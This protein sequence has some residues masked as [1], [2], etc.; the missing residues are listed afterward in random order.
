MP[1]SQSA[2]PKV[3]ILS[4][5]S[6]T[7]KLKPRRGRVARA[8]NSCR[9]KKKRCDGLAPCSVCKV[10]GSVCAYSEKRDSN[11]SHQRAGS[12]RLLSLGGSGGLKGREALI[13]LP[14]REVAL[15][16]IHKTWDNACVLFRFHYRPSIIRILNSLYE[17]KDPSQYTEEQIK[18]QP[19]IYS[20]L[21]VGVLFAKEDL[22]HTDV[23]ARDF[24]QDE[25][26]KYFLAAKSLV[27]VTNINDIFAIQ[28]MFMMTMF[29]Q[30]SANLKK[31]YAYIGIALRAA[32]SEG[33]HRKNSLVGPTP[34]EDETKKR[35][36]WTI[37]KVD[38]YMSCIL[39]LPQ[40]IS[41]SAV[42]QE[43]PR[44]VD[45][46]RITAD[47]IIEQEWGKI[48]SC[49]MN[50]AHTNLMLIMASIHEKLYPVLKWDQETYINILDLQD[51]LDRWVLELPLQLKPD[52][53]FI[54]KEDKDYYL[55][56]NKLLYLDY[57]LAKIILY[58][59]FIHYIAI[60]PQ[61]VPIY[62]F[63]ILMAKNCIQVAHEVIFLSN[64]MMENDLLS[65]SYWYSI[66]T[67]FFSVTC[68]MFYQHQI[69]IGYIV[70]N[71]NDVEKDCNLGID[72]LL[73]LKNS[74]SAGERSFNALNSI[75]KEFNKKTTELFL[76]VERNLQIQETSEDIVSRQREG[77]IS[78]TD[79]PTNSTLDSNELLDQLLQDFD[80][81]ISSILP[82]FEMTSFFPQAT[83]NEPQ[84]EEVV[85]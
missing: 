83:I 60:D 7:K 59:P 65:G 79:D 2:Q 24:Y 57:L 68:L 62:E 53:N 23:A 17:I 64:E 28:T 61:K 75:F 66:H 39:G 56:P 43:F 48:S 70:K 20:V 32:I 58:K 41:Q 4:L 18:A 12:S 8:C 6:S 27:D 38:L 51:R 21:A 85:I 67:I 82:D 11:S 3:L 5:D 40:S 16:L 71:G 80:I 36:F 69:N 15:R 33:L 84:T 63:Q 55:K 47:G 50:N 54:D 74:S 37:Y 77:P 45:D 35:L 13:P 73:E 14:E 49:G 44:D 29:L 81:P 34:I 22:K 1:T 72:I 25:G 42:N 46:E 31:C 10:I 76:Q 52:Y 9:L 78:L 26:Y 30:C 19:L